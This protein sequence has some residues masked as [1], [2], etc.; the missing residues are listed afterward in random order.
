MARRVRHFSREIA[1]A[2]ALSLAAAVFLFAT[3]AGAPVGNLPESTADAS[4]NQMAN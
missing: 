4:S 3:F 1:I 2:L